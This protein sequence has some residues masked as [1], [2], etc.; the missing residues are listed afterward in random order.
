MIAGVAV[1]VEVLREPDPKRTY[2]FSTQPF[3][4][5][6]LALVNHPLDI[7]I[8]CRIVPGIISLKPTALRYMDSI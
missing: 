3:K 2:D 1:S 6:H 5:W 8:G 7:D 4:I